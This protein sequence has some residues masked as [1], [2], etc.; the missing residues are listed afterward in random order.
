MCR[1]VFWEIN[2]FAAKGKGEGVSRIQHPWEADH[3]SLPKR[4]WVQELGL[5][6]GREVEGPPP[7]KKI[8]KLGSFD[9]LGLVQVKKFIIISTLNIVVW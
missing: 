1:L 2:T 4:H 5:S 6:V 8:Q 9:Y 3:V 7:K